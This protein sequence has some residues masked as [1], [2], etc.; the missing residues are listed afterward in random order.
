MIRVYDE[1]GNIAVTHEL[2]LSPGRRPVHPEHEEM[3]RAYQDKKEARKSTSV[4]AFILT[5]PDQAD[6]MEAL[7]K[8]QGANLYAHLR[9]IVSYTDIYPVEEVSRIL[10]ECMG[11]GAFHKNTVKRLLASKALK[12]PVLPL[13]GFAGPAPL[14]RNLAVYLGVVYE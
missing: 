14:V 8:A 11:M 10:H 6:Y 3:N 9:E 12:V 7:R 4:K 1:K 2:S 13:S 5:F